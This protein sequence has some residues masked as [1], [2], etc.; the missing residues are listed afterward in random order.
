[1]ARFYITTPIFYVNARPHIGHAY[2]MIAADAVARYHRMLGEPTY[3]LTGTD[4]HGTKI[5]RAA[6][7][8]G[9]APKEFTDRIAGSF[10]D[11]ALEL[12]ISN[13][14][15]IRTT[16]QE[17]HWPG[18]IALW[19]KLEAS[20]AL[21]RGSYEGLYCV[22]HEAFIRKS[23]LIDGL[24]PDHKT[25][26]ELIREDN[27][28]FALSRYKDQ[29]R[30]L[31]ESGDMRILPESRTKEALNMLDELE[32]ISFSRP[33]KD[34]TWGI[35][36]P[37]DDSQTVY[38][39]CDALTNY[40]SAIGFGRSEE[41]QQWW[42]ANAHVIGKDIL[43]FHAI[44]WP[45]MLLAAG[46]ATPESLLVHGFITVD[47]QKMSKTI[48]N[49]INPSELVNQY[50]LDPVRYFLLREIPSNEDGDFSYKNLEN[51]YNT[52]LANGLGNLVQ[53]VATLVATKMSGKGVYGADLEATEASLVQILDD[54][55]YKKAFEQFRLHDATANVWEKI[56]LANAYLNDRQPWKQEGEARYKTLITT[57]AMIA[58]IAWV[59]QPFMPTTAKKVAEVFGVPLDAQL[60]D[61]QHISVTLPEPLFP[62]TERK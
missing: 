10:A 61:S 38:V 60:A 40:L 8:A 62:R 9:V 19:H 59:L 42:P 32:D 51:R 45:G 29:I 16:D 46:L 35:P 55:D 58:H 4:E 25:S 57:V 33:R 30:R 43:R 31:Y 34:L 2:T 23:D 5:A 26:P 1:M 21:Y 20:G 49:V 39:W 48:G 22:G 17:L 18:V 24:C 44:I 7:Q 52:D 14:Q 47:G 28:F 3:F 11:M 56:A 15:F 6:E 13:D 53:R 12:G 37:G 50:G 41:Y 27:W 54:T 36:V